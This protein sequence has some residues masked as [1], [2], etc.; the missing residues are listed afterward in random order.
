M[1]H[2]SLNVFECIVQPF[3]DFQGQLRSLAGPSET[4]KAR[5]PPSVPLFVFVPPAHLSSAPTQL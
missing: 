3:L 2:Q 4:G 1:S 5:P